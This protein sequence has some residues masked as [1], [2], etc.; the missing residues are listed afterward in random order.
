MNKINITPSAKTRRAVAELAAA[1]DNLPLDAATVGA[2]K[3]HAEAIKLLVRRVRSNIIEI[4]HHLTKAQELAGRGNWLRWLDQEFNWSEQ[5]A[6]NYMRVYEM[7]SIH[8]SVVDLDL[9][10]RS[11]YLLAQPSTPE[12]V[13][14]DVIERAANGEDL[15]H[16]E[17][18]AAVDEARPAKP[19]RPSHIPDAE[20]VR[21]SGIAAA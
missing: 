10:M 1:V 14:Q 15:S 4:G 12:A 16:A 17:V 7:A 6:R 9:P 13:R 8:N 5:T 18:K 20:R 2:L 21:Q 3:R 19:R 11:L